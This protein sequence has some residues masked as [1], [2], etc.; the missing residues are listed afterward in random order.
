MLVAGTAIE[1]RYEAGEATSVSAHREVAIPATTSGMDRALD[2]GIVRLCAVDTL[3][4]SLGD[5][6]LEL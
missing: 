3:L 4:A 5:V 1:V 2:A 6:V